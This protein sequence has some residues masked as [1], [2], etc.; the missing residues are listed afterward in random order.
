M[1]ATVRIPNHVRSII[2]PDG[3]VILDIRKGKYYSLNG[4]GA[5]I[6]IK[7]EAGMS[8]PEIENHLSTTY[9]TPSEL[10][11]QDVAGFIASLQQK[12]LVNVTA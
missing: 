9:A 12:Q 7:L 4:V 1:Q 3:A 10:V 8:V 11:R 2:D 6:W 5:Q